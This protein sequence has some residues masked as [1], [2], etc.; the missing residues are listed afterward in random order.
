MSDGEEATRFR[1]MSR[2]LLMAQGLT[3]TS[4]AILAACGSSSASGSASP[5]PASPSEG[6]EDA[7]LNLL[8][9]PNVP[10]LVTGTVAGRRS[11]AAGSLYGTVPRQTTSIKGTFGGFVLYALL[12]QQ[13]QVPIGAGL[14]RPGIPGDSGLTTHGPP[15][16]GAFGPMRTVLRS[17]ASS[18]RT[19]KPAHRLKQCGLSALIGACESFVSP[20]TAG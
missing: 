17:V 15:V 5:A 9:N 14:N 13:D 20:R 1:M 8:L 6:L 16:G 12:S 10:A 4:A 18:H 19:L 7:K 3:V 11:N 2:R